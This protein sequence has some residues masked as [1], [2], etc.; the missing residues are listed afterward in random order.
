[1]ELEA[2]CKLTEAFNDLVQSTRGKPNHT[3]E[4]KIT[5][6]LEAGAKHTLQA[7]LT[8]ELEA[9][10]KHTL[11]AKLTL[12]LETGAKHTQGAMLTETSRVVEHHSR[13]P[14]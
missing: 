10:A 2:F 6:K 7:K 9:G 14:R 1:M 8:L 13:H 5:L 11:Q 3:L 4:A 12:E